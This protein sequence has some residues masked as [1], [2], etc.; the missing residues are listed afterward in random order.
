MGPL[1]VKVLTVVTGVVRTNLARNSAE[2]KLPQESYYQSIAASIGARARLEDAAAS[3][4]EAEVYAESIVR[5]VLAEMDGTVWR[6]A[7]ATVLQFFHLLLPKSL[8][9]SDCSF[10]E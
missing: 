6:G 1:G 9:V 7:F 2:F 3:G 4:T 10:W 8:L 5:G